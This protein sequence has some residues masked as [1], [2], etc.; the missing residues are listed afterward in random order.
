[1]EANKMFCN[2]PEDDKYFFPQSW[3]TIVITS[4]NEVEDEGAK[5]TTLLRTG[6]ADLVHIRKPEWT[7]LQVGELLSTIPV[8]YHHNLVLHGHYGLRAYFPAISGVQIRR[9]EEIDELSPWF[10]TETIHSLDEIP[11]ALE[12][13]PEYVTLSP[14]YDSISKPGYKSAFNPAEVSEVVRNTPLRFIALGGVRPEN[15]IE[16][17]RAGFSGAALLGYVWSDFSAALPAL[18]KYKGLVANFQFQFITNPSEYA[19]ESIP[20]AENALRGGCRWMQLRL[21]DADEQT[22]T[23]CAGSI[24]LMCERCHAT[25]IIDDNVQVAKQLGVGVHLGKDDM[26][27]AEARRILGPGAIIGVT[28]NTAEDIARVNAEGVADYIGLG[29]FRHTTTKKKLAPVLGLDGCNK[30]L[31]DKEL[32]KLPIVVIGGITIDDL[33]S[34]VEA[35]A[36]GVAVSGALTNKIVHSDDAAIY[37]E[38]RAETEKFANEVNSIFD[39][40]TAK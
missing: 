37:V 36:D 11:G 39:A 9:P 19:V 26:S 6:A 17:Y 33:P 21:K 3:L 10:N 20:Q 31:S 13:D 38:F 30:L 14:I 28:C 1:M 8:E 15:F 34:L 5:I 24:K 40:R 16:L 18:L 35:G 22:L 4:P 25:L 23:L 32:H 12:R 27:A 2:V 29:P 7:E